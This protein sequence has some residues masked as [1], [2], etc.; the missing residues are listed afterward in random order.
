MNKYL[1]ALLYTILGTLIGISYVKEL[2]PEQKLLVMAG[3]VGTSIPLTPSIP[4]AV[5]REFD[6]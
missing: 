2:N 4:K 1:Q 6:D 3:I 5:R